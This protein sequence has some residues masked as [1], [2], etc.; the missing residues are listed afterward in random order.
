MDN[1]YEMNQSDGGVMQLSDN[2]LIPY[3]CY[4]DGANWANEGTE[5]TQRH[6][7]E[8][9]VGTDTYADSL[10]SAG[11]CGVQPLFQLNSMQVDMGFDSEIER[12]LPASSLTQQSVYRPD[13]QGFFP[14]YTPQE[15]TN[16]VN[17]ELVTYATS[18]VSNATFSPRSANGQLL[19]SQ[20]YSPTDQSTLDD[21]PIASACQLGNNGNDESTYSYQLAQSTLNGVGDCNS[22][23]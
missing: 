4:H 6:C 19:F 16:P 18:T 12:F 5:S 20:F 22:C 1:P 17:D 14:E 23:L 13:P 11:N 3:F 10:T 9:N 2:R 21:Q 15:N 7:L 8:P